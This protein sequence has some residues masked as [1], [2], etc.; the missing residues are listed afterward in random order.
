MPTMH[1]AQPPGVSGEH[2]QA[3]GHHR[4]GRGII[5]DCERVKPVAQPGEPQKYAGD[6]PDPE[7]ASREP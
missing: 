7:R 3:G 4:P 6:D 2:Q 1:M 5:N